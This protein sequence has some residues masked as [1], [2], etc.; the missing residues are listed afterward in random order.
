LQELI[1]LPGER[2][3]LRL[4]GNAVLAVAGDAE[5]ELVLDRR[6]IGGGARRR[7]PQQ[8]KQRHGGEGEA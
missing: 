1:G 2:G 4:V 7:D 6:D 5:L 3:N 8:A